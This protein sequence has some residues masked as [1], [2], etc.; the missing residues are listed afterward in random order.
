MLNELADF[1]TTNGDPRQ[2]K[3]TK[4]LSIV[5]DDAMEEMGE[6]DSR[7]LAGW[8]HM[9]ACVIEWTAS[10]NMDVL[11]EELIEFACKVEGIQIPVAVVVDD[12]Q[13]VDAEIV[14]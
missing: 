9:M 6:M 3:M 4:L 7:V 11:P 12:E 1:V 8:M 14:G 13:P 5:I 2:K 10:G